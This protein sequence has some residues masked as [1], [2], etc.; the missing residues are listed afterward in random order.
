MMPFLAPL[1]A[2]WRILSAKPSLT[3]IGALIALCGFLC[4][5]L[6]MVDGERDKWRDRAKQ[7]EAASKAVVEADKRADA[8]GTVKAGEVKKGID[9]G[10]ERA[11]QAAAGSDDPLRSGFDSLRA[12]NNR[13]GGQAPR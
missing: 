4:L 8:A 6:S 3:A 1:A 2:L 9:D 13:G 11:K 10:N 7:Y 5:R 12:E